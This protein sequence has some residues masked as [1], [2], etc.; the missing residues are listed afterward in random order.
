MTT[1][2]AVYCKLT[3]G[4]TYVGLHLGER[5]EDTRLRADEASRAAKGAGRNHMELFVPKPPE[6]SDP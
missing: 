5:P 3:W 2:R 6:Q 1:A 4:L